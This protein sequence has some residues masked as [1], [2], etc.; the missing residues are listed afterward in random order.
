MTERDNS[1]VLGVYYTS[2]SSGNGF[3]SFSS[4]EYLSRRIS[5]ILVHHCTHQIRIIASSS[6]ALSTFR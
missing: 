6:F 5:S 3:S 4:G 1:T 2:F